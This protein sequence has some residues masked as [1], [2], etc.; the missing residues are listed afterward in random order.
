MVWLINY[1]FHR[2]EV[3]QCEK[4]ARI[5]YAVIKPADKLSK[6]IVRAYRE[7]AFE[8]VCH[9]PV[10]RIMSTAAKATG[11]NSLHTPLLQ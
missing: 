3:P 4:A 11:E 6:R 10:E 7:S 8:A 2:G 5:V 1:P 9:P